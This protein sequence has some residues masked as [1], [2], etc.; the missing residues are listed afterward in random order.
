LERSSGG[1]ALRRDLQGNLSVEGGTGA[2]D[3]VRA[4]A[5]ARWSVRLG[6]TELLTRGY[7]GAGTDE[8]PPH[9][10]FVLGGRGTL[11]GEPFRAYGGRIAGLVHLEWRLDIP[12]PAVSLGS[13]ASTGTRATLAPFLSLGYAGRPVAGLPWGRTDGVRPV[14]GL[15]VEWFMRLIRLELGIGLRSGDVGVTV[16]VNRDW[17]GLL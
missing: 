10:S 5:A 3:Y 1:I 15:A 11:V 14:A 13:F 4:T 7:F 12:V 8:T 2:D 17:W 16:D 6:H 9:R